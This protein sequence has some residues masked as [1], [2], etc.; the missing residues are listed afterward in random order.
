MSR[1]PKFVDL[2][3][4]LPEGLEELGAEFYSASEGQFYSALT[5]EMGRVA[6]LAL[7]FKGFMICL[8]ELYLKYLCQVG[9]RH[10]MKFK[11]RKLV[12]L[13]VPI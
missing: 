8:K 13:I 2:P 1:L 10:T 7:S 11:M 4:D 5:E 6:L 12:P 9:N 3:A